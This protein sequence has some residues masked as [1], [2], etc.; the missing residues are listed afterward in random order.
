[1][2]PAI[3]AIRESIFAFR[4]TRPFF[5]ARIL[6]LL[7]RAHQHRKKRSAG[8]DRRK[9]IPNMTLIEDRPPEVERPQPQKAED[10][11]RKTEVR[12]RKLIFVFGLLSSDFG[13]PN[14]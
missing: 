13:L 3:S 11:S 5:R 10:R 8:K 6:T 12:S 4:Q 14:V 9:S 2:T 7:R 1:M